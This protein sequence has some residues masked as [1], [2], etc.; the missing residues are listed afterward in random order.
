M[1]T[2]PDERRAIRTPYT[3]RRYKAYWAISAASGNAVAIVFKE[4]QARWFCLCA[5]YFD[6]MLSAVK[7]FRDEL[8]SL[9]F[10]VGRPGYRDVI[11][12]ANEMK[13]ARRKTFKAT[14]PAEHGDE[15]RQSEM[16]SS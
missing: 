8:A 2:D 15:R 1:A 9:G 12:L 10:P 13:I 5:N 7:L 6:R 4:D 3:Y 16:S 11:L 14:P